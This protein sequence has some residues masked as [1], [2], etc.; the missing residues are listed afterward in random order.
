MPETLLI[1]VSGSL[2][3][4]GQRTSS[5]QLAGTTFPS[6]PGGGCRPGRVGGVRRSPRSLR[7]R[8]PSGFCHLEWG[9][10]PRS[11]WLSLSWGL[12][13]SGEKAGNPGSLHPR[14]S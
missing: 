8:L 4:G 7:S 10:L 2:G 5:G 9:S 1:R 3:L 12:A 6:R 14:V 11:G 13:L